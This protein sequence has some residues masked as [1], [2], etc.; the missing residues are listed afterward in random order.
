[1]KGIFFNHLS[2]HSNAGRPLSL[3]IFNQSTYISALEL[4]DCPYSFLT[5]APFNAQSTGTNWQ[6]IM[7]VELTG[8]NQNK[9]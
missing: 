2:Q 4:E 6:L 3:C 7:H 9:I 8:S 1:M 5:T